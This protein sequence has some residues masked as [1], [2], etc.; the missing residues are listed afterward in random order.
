ME[1]DSSKS[2]PDDSQNQ[3]NPESDLNSDHSRN[4]D[5]ISDGEQEH[6]EETHSEFM[7]QVVDIPETSLKPKEPSV[8]KKVT[9]KERKQPKMKPKLKPKAVKGEESRYKTELW[10]WEKLLSK[11]EEFNKTSIDSLPSASDVNICKL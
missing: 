3:Q 5:S 4:N 1:I 6:S 11:K 8:L 7:K 9:R 2:S 10:S